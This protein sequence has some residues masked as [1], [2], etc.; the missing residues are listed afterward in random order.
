MKQSVDKFQKTFFLTKVDM[1][2]QQMLI[3]EMLV[4]PALCVDLD[5][6]IRA[7]RSGGF[8]D[9][10]EDI[11][12]L[13]N[14]EETL[15]RYRNAGY[16]VFG[17]TNQGG[18]AYGHK[19]IKQVNEEIEA[20]LQL[21]KENPFH[22]VKACYQMA[23]GKVPA[24][25][26]RSLHRKPGIGMLALMEVAAWDSGFVVDWDNSIMVGDGEE[27]KD[28]AKNADIAFLWADYFFSRNTPEF[29]SGER[30]L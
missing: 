7:S 13:P 20:T 22:M 14:T 28:L 23:G 6:T 26:Y 15:W 3:R 17:V 18:V 12:L 8:I 27:D 5:G 25:S 24:Y 1:D 9:G 29:K 30:L 2:N 11:V 4:R 21:F 10:P 16:L 19:T